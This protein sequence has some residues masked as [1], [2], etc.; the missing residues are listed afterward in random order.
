VSDVLEINVEVATW[1]DADRIAA[2][3]SAKGLLPMRASRRR[4]WFKARRPNIGPD[5]HAGQA[6]L[7]DAANWEEEAFSLSPSG[8]EALARTVLKLGEIVPS[9]WTLRSYW[10]GDSVEAERFVSPEE[11]ADLVREGALLRTTLY[12]VR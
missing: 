10:V 9:G 2:E 8:R 12:R 1:E 7:D 5:W 3:T 6:V 4:G 11:V